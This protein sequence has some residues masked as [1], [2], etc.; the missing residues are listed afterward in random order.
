MTKSQL[1]ILLGSLVFTVSSHALSPEAI[2]GKVLFPSCDVCHDQS[3]TPALGP[4]MWGVQRRYKK[5]TTDKADFIQRMTSFVKAPT[6]EA[7]IHDEARGQL[8]LMPALPLP[9]EML[10]KISAYIFEEQFPPPCDH[11]RYAVKKAKEGGDSD[12][13]IKDQ[14]QLDRFCK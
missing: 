12:H 2:E 3:N 8:G 7:A 1:T 5:D 6:M 9:D 13:A 11:W 4:P 10:N 14:R